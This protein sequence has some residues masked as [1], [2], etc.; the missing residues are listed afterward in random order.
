MCKEVDVN[1]KVGLRRTVS[2]EVHKVIPALTKFDQSRDIFIKGQT[3]HSSGPPRIA[4][5]NHE[6]IFYWVVFQGSVS[7]SVSGLSPQTS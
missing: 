5:N 7:N 6:N 1:L 2:C 4:V 3:K